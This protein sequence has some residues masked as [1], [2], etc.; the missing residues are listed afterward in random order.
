MAGTP[1]PNTET[2]ETSGT[3]DHAVAA[4]MTRVGERV[5][6]AR[7]RKAIPRRVLSNISGVSPR[8]LAQL[9]A[10][11]GNISIGLLQ[12]VAIALDH[13][14]EWFLAEDDPWSSEALRVANLYRGAPEEVRDAAMKILSPEPIAAMRARRVCL[15]GLRGAGKSTL[16][17]RVGEVLSLPFVELN[18]EIESQSGMPVDEVMALYGPEGYRKLEAQ[19]LARIV[20]SHDKMILAV[21]GG[22]VA[23][24]ET[25]SSLLAHF[26]TVW[27]KTSPDEHMARV[28]AQGDERPMAGNPEAMEQLRSILTSREA[29]YGKALAQLDTS[30]KPVERSLAE[31]L[32]LIQDHRFLI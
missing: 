15:V 6:R 12:R 31:L 24:P 17:R 21:A 4:V 19:A 25:Y 14:I 28:R 3:A 8:Y 16:G 7:E 27:V 32:Q 13:R 2:D 29:Q 9:E 20:A 5:R 30:G 26:H 10:G 22:I 18:D 11:E 23:E 1:T